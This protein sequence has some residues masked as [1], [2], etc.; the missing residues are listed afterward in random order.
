MAREKNDGGFLH[1][2]A[3]SMREGDKGGGRR[4]VIAHR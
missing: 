4:G 1:G 3:Q 2:S